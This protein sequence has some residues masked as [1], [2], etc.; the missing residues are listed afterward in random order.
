MGNQQGGM[1]SMG[2][3]QG[4][5]DG[6]AA[7]AGGG[8]RPGFETA[9]GYQDPDA[10]TFIAA[11]TP[12]YVNVYHLMPGPQTAVN[13]ALMGLGVFHSGVE[14]GNVEFAFGGDASSPNRPGVFQHPPKAI[15]PAPQFH[16]SHHVGNLPKNV[17]LQQ[18]KD[19][20]ESLGDPR[21]GGWTCGS[22]NLM[23][24][25]CNHFAEAFVAELSQRFVEAA[26]GAPLVYP[27]YINRAA[28]MGTGIIPPPML[29][30]FQQAAPKAPG[31]FPDQQPQQRSNTT[32]NAHSAGGGAAPK[33]QPKQTPKPDWEEAQEAK[34]KSAPKPSATPKA[35]PAAK[36]AVKTE[37]ELSSMSARDLRDLAKAHG[38]D[39]RTLLEK[40][41]YVDAIAAAQRR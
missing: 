14:V 39:P 40:S 27:G 9:Q 21:R 16:R 10:S 5:D 8:G 4:G 11:G 35:A 38:I 1:G 28:K 41:D 34:P 32:S 3:Q 26:G 20:A 29:A 25:N 18:V 2:G 15:L 31:G 13:G 7:G 23:L 37:A 6:R 33:P 36:P 12:V 24:R 19:I 22:Y 17:S 30:M